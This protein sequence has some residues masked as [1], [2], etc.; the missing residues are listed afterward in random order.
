M[1]TIRNYI[2]RKHGKIGHA[3]LTTPDGPWLLDGHTLPASS[4]EHF[5]YFALQSL[6]DA[7]AGY[8]DDPDGA[9]VAWADK[10]QKL[11]DG[12]LGVRGGGTDPVE[13]EMRRLVRDLWLASDAGNKAKWKVMDDDERAEHCDG[14]IAKQDD[15]TQEKL[16]G[17]AVENVAKAEEERKRKAA[18]AARVA[19]KLGDFVL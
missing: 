19:N 1:E 11:I 4:V 2:H 3:T 8:A 14:L 18:D 7:Y 17:F 9:K 15:A 16:R 13:A 5:A 10:R 12:T 6:Q